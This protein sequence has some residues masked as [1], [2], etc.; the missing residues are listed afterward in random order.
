MH[1]ITLPGLT[2]Y[3]AARE[4][5]LKLVEE[6]AADLIPDTFLFLEHPP[7]ITRGRGLQYTGEAG[8]RHMPV[9]VNLPPGIHFAEAERGGDL[10]CHG[11]GQ[12]VI[13]PICKLDGSG[14]GPSQNVVGF[15]R[16]L[17]RVLIEELAEWGIAAE[18]RAH[19]TGVWVEGRKVASLGIAVRKWVI[20]HGMAIN[21]VNDLGLFQLISPCG[22]SPDVMTKVV[23]LKRP[24]W[25][26]VSE[27]GEAWVK[28][29]AELERRIWV[30][31]L[32]LVS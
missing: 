8:P 20:Y 15:I 19:A 3:E 12:L 16:K 24:S 11:P 2:D 22:F 30:R 5:Q 23:D 29:R 28:V 13:Y 6:R 32:G 17:E 7:T 31:I 1:K 10:T 9:P 27:P 21:C 18:S 25:F 14:F 26:Q 4:L